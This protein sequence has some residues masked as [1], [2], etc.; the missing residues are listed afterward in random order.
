M[1]LFSFLK[2]AALL[3]CAAQIGVSLS[4]LAAPITFINPLSTNV[5][6]QT[7]AGGTDPGIFR[8]TNG[9]G[10]LLDQASSLF[11]LNTADA[12]A[13]VDAAG[14][15]VTAAVHADVSNGGYTAG[16]R[17]YA[18]LANPFFVVPRVGFVGS[19]AMIR[20]PYHFSGSFNNTSNCPSCFEFVD[21]RLGVDGVTGGLSFNGAHSLGT[22]NNPTYVA[23][24]VDISGLIEGL[25]P[26]NTEL[27]LRGGLQAGVHC[28]SL[29]GFGAPKSCDAEALFGGTLSYNGFSPDAVD[30]V[31]GLTP[32]AAVTQGV[33]EPASLFLL[34]TGLLGLAV[35]RKT[36]GRI[37]PR[38]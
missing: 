2:R 14:L 12:F 24:G 4:A 25:V 19:Q 20:V 34:A 16:A 27:Y 6:V 13:Q 11:G 37:P 3:M 18:G 9:S 21:A 35:R 22:I 23:G 10:P 7:G 5:G 28:Q 1:N 36:V 38:W 32:A 26:V 17:G 29:D 30:I 33:P 15:H 8:N 31:W